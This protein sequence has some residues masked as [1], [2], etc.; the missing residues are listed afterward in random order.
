[1]AEKSQI[2]NDKINN[3][4][5]NTILTKYKNAV[6]IKDANIKR[7]NRILIKNL[8][9]KLGIKIDQPNYIFRKLSNSIDGFYNRLRT[10]VDGVSPQ[11]YENTKII[12]HTATDGTKDRYGNYIVSAKTELVPS[13]AYSKTREGNAIYAKI[14]A[15]INNPKPNNRDVKIAGPGEPATSRQTIEIKRPGQNGGKTRKTRQHKIKHNKTAN[16]SK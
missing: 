5:I 7:E 6:E 1:M 16:K 3:T 11:D 9:D 8:S 14:M 10:M 2:N 13:N 15:Q 12:I 4:E